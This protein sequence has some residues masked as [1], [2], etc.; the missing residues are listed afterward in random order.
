MLSTDA[1][2]ILSDDGYKPSDISEMFRS[3]ALEVTTEDISNHWKK[4]FCAK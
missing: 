1:C 2:I 4:I 3:G